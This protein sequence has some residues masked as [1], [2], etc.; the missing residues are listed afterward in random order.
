MPQ[1]SE[2]FV[3]VEFE[4]LFNCG[5]E[6]AAAPSSTFAVCDRSAYRA[7]RTEEEE[8]DMWVYLIHSVRHVAF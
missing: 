2:P 3:Q 4:V 8:I 5:T 6:E 7:A 1:N